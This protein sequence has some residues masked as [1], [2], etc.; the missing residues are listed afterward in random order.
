MIIS[1]TDT[2]EN[3]ISQ[4]C[5]TLSFYLFHC[6]GVLVFTLGLSNKVFFVRPRISLEI[7]FLKMFKLLV[8]FLSQFYDLVS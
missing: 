1:E 2:G 7:S 5:A 4:E 8:V 6:F 3:V